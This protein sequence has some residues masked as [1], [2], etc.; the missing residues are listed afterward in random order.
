MARQVLLGD[1]ALALGAVHAGLSAAYSYPGTPASE[2][3][4]FLIRLAKKEG[5][6]KATWSVNEKVAYEEALGASFA[7]K[8]AMVSFK[9]VGLNV[10]ADPFMNS[11]MTGA[12]GGLVVVSADDPGMHSSQ[13]EQ[14]SRFYAQFARVLCL[15]PADH[16]ECYDLARRAFDLSEATGLPVL[17]RLV[18]RLSH[19]RSSVET[20]EPRPQNPLRTGDWK[21]WTL[22]PVNARR[23][24]RLLIDRQAELL[25]LA[26]ALPA[27]ALI[28]NDKDRSLGV[29]ASGIAANYF[30]E[31]A[32][33]E[34]SAPSFL[35][36]SSFPLPEK[37]VRALVG[38]VET[39]L[40]LEDGYPLIEKELQGFFG[41]PGKRVVGRTSGA[42]PASGELNPDIVRTALGL[43]P[44][45]SRAPSGVPLAGRPPQL[46]VGCP[47][48][49]TFKALNEARAAYPGT[50]VFSDIGCYTLGALPPY[51]A[52][53]SCVCMGA[54]VGMARG[55]SDVGVR[56]AVAVI[57]DSTF[58]HSGMTPLL[59]A[60]DANADMTL[61]I[62]DNATVAMTGGQPT[63]GSGER[64]LRIVEALGVP[65]EHLRTIEPL[66]KNHGKNVQVMK[67]EFEYRGLSVIVAVRECVQEQRKRRS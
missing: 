35:K 52:I 59:G 11:A 1:E 62:L 9:H 24:F 23:R 19:S 28:L 14:D 31:A 54:S 32:A 40:V 48:A 16:Q 2:I 45:P 33:K 21:D 8:R 22:L 56:P 29:I 65:K 26:E 30:R 57:G 34:E 47:H 3:M 5:G 43:A 61:I 38:H 58:A 6:F 36:V 17:I 39:V 25:R 53:Q 46:C 15:E 20:G 63:Y 42:V 60:A 41:V 51:N 7:G 12:N 66:P 49:D 44:L 50:S 13:N 10:A 37:L 4:E 18:T 67:E 64:L 27:N 55:A